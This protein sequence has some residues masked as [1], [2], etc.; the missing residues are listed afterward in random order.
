MDRVHRNDDV[1]AILGRDGK[2]P[3][4]PH[5]ELGKVQLSAQS[6]CPVLERERERCRAP[7]GP[8]VAAP[9]HV[10]GGHQHVLDA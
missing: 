8:Q 6:L 3:G 10:R 2:P 5:Q 1:V 9:R 7:G 4:L